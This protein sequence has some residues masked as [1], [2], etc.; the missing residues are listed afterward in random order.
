MIKR[1]PFYGN[2]WTS[3]LTSSSIVENT[4][5]YVDSI[6]RL[7]YNNQFYIVSDI[8]FLIGFK[9]TELVNN[10]TKLLHLK[11]KLNQR[12]AVCLRMCIKEL[13]CYTVLPPANHVSDD[14]K[15][16][17]FLNLNTVLW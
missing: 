16:I 4:F 17:F 11:Q 3:S 8:G 5:F 14:S 15:E 6:L 9:G 7:E 12:L 2:W 10:P 1:K 13:K